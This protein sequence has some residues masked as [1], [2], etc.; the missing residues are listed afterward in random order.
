MLACDKVSKRPP[1]T[2]IHGNDGRG[3]HQVLNGRNRLRMAGMEIEITIARGKNGSA[4]AARQA[5]P[6]PGWII[7]AADRALKR[8]KNLAKL[9]C[10]I[11]LYVNKKSD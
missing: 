2:F 4:A 7:G 3:L 5:F 8:S 11:Y 10:H 9:L 6:I 1:D